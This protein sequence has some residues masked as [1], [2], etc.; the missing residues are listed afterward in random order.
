MIP[1]A[2][3]HPG[4]VRFLHRSPPSNESE[5]GTSCYSKDAY[6]FRKWQHVVAVKD[7]SH[8][9]LYLNGALV[10]QG[11]DVSPLPANMR[12]LIGRLYPSRRVRPLVGQLDELAVYNRALTPR[13]IS[14]HY[15][16]VRPKQAVVTKP[17]I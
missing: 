5:L 9:S 4:R 17:T 6:T 2:T 3:H 15:R 10:G 13:E 12:L 16:L 7:G 14:S 11:E 8:M 1:S